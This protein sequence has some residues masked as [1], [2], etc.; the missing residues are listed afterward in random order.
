MLLLVHG[1]VTRK[2]LKLWHEIL[3][4]EGGRLE[5]CC[6]REVLIES[7]CIDIGN[8]TVTDVRRVATGF[9]EFNYL[10]TFVSNKSKI[11]D[12]IQF[13]RRMTSSNSRG[14]VE[15]FAALLPLFLIA[16]NLQSSHCTTTE[17]MPEHVRV[18]LWTKSEWKNR[19]YIG[20]PQSAYIFNDSEY[21]IP[22]TNYVLCDI[23]MTHISSSDI[24]HLLFSSRARVIKHNVISISMSDAT[25]VLYCICDW[26]FD[27]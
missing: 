22:S 25:S 21:R 19:L 23:V 18:D 4:V 8:G 13:E 2:T 24:I 3:I 15:K 17:E 26:K 16:V 5:L 7:L 20:Q 6:S 1:F 10:R 9:A 12:L 14:L 11:A 27:S